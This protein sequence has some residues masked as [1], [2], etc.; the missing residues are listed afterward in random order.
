MALVVY[1]LSAAEQQLFLSDTSLFS[2]NHTEIK[3]E[4]YL[5][6]IGSHLKHVTMQ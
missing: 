6:M 3:I 5:V 2:N 4:G 1:S